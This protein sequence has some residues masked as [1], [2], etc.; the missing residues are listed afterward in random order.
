MTT[1]VFKVED[2]ATHWVVARHEGEAANLIAGSYGMTRSDWQG[3][4]E[5]EIEKLREYDRVRINLDVDTKEAA[6][7]VH[8]VPAVKGDLRVS[9]YHESYAKDWWG[10]AP[11]IICS[12]EV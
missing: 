5:V 7:H 10:R 2:G 8:D 4:Y 3:E 12:T 9:A 6:Q 1:Y 11:E